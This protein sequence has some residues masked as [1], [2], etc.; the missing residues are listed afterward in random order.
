MDPVSITAVATI[1]ILFIFLIAGWTSFSK[2]LRARRLALL[3]DSLKRMKAVIAELTERVN[4]ADQHLNYAPEKRSAAT[5]AKLE[6]A[7]S[8]LVTITDCL[9]TIEQLIVERRLNDAA[10]LLSA[11]TRV[12][13]KVMRVLAQLDPL[14]IEHRPQIGQ[15]KPDNSS[16]IK[17]QDKRRSN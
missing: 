10:D 14:L 2:R 13:E 5:S 3:S 4:D 6:S 12:I 15:T 11:S 1:A 9:P 16:V 17:L 8:D 7:A